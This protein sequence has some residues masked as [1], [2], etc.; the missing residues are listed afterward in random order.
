VK[1][2][3]YRPTGA[4]EHADPGTKVAVLALLVAALCGFLAG[5]V[6]TAVHPLY[7]ADDLVQDPTLLGAWRTPDG[8]GCW[9]FAEGEGKGYRVEIQI[10]DQRVICVAH[11]FRLG[12]ERFLDLY[13]AEQPLGATLEN[14]P[15]KIGLVPTHVFIRV[16]EM[17]P[18]LRMSCMGLDWLKERCKRDSQAPAHVM[19]PDGRVV[20]TGTTAVLQAFIKEHLNDAD[21]WNAMYDDGLVRNVAKPTRQ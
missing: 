6:P 10:D 16:H 17:S 21:A 18:K 13:P 5:C 12:N 8:K 14:N 7:R 15:Y 3:N 9:T 19:L 2:T 11:L 1:I 20:L 4:E